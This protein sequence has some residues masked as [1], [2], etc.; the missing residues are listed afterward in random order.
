[1]VVLSAKLGALG[2][3]GIR[4]IGAPTKLCSFVQARHNACCAWDGLRGRWPQA[5]RARGVARKHRARATS[6]GA[7]HEFV[8]A[9]KEGTYVSHST[10]H[11]GGSAASDGCD[12]DPGRSRL[13]AR[14]RLS[15]WLRRLWLRQWMRRRMWGM[16]RWLRDGLRQ[17]LPHHLSNCRADHHGSP[18]RYRV[19]HV[20][21]DPMAA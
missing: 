1:M 17:R 4:L 11:D 18:N 2:A 6:N 3:V 21:H 19:P 10:F 20:Q 13:A 8:G 9:G 5:I 15:R 14:S 7:C 12:G 16:R